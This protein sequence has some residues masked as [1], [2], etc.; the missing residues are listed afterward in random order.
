MCEINYI[1]NGSGAK[2][3][4]KNNSKKRQI[5]FAFRFIEANR[6]V[7]PT[8][9]ACRL[10]GHT[11]RPTP[12][13]TRVPTKHYLNTTAIPSPSLYDHSIHLLMPSSNRIMQHVTKLKS[14]QTGFLNNYLTELQWRLVTGSQSNKAPLGCGGLGN[15]H[16]GFIPTNLRQMCDLTFLFDFPLGIDNIFLN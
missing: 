1:G 14:S 15:S 11:G 5:L 8:V 3:E 16:H 2:R 6:A 9:Q 7:V 10:A 4:K 12:D 13:Q